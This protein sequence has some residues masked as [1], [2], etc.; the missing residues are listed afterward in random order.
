MKPPG[1]KMPLTSTSEAFFSLMCVCKCLEVMIWIFWIS[2]YKLSQIVRHWIN[3]YYMG[4]TNGLFVH[5]KKCL[6]MLGSGHIIPL[7]HEQLNKYTIPSVK[8]TASQNLSREREEK[9]AKWKG[10][11][12]SGSLIW[13]FNLGGLDLTAPSERSCSSNK[14]RSRSDLSLRRSFLRSPRAACLT[15]LTEKAM[16][17]LRPCLDSCVGFSGVGVQNWSWD[18]TAL[19]P[20]IGVPKEAEVFLLGVV[21]WS[22]EGALVE[23]MERMEKLGIDWKEVQIGFG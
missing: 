8:H 11:Y 15:S 2:S 17:L 10:L 21:M 14:A 20:L 22:R 13:F 1:G 23:S 7:N 12:F 5:G 4:K 9:V 6:F 16:L 18:D 19:F 3:Y